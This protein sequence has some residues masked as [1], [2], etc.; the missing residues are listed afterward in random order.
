M[1]LHKKRR[2]G[3]TVSGW[4]FI[5]MILLGSVSLSAC[6]VDNN[7]ERSTQP[8]ESVGPGGRTTSGGVDVRNGEQIYFT[9][10]NRDGERISYTEGPDFG[11]MMMGSY[12]TCAACHGPEAQ[13]GRHA[14]HMQVMDAPAITFA[15]LSG[16]GEEH[17]EEEGDHADEHGE[18]DLEAFRMAVVDGQHPDGEALDKNMP[19]WNINEDDLKDLFAFLK[20]LSP[21]DV[22][23][24]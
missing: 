6:V 2:A 17:G 24:Q 5:A 20:S 19:R 4:F 10:T 12:L 3:L 15:A 13:G 23:N 21:S 8:L 14:M 9:T 7:A 16:E 11:G 22:D 1:N 18:Y